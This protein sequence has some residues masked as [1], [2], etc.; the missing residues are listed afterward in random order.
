MT[1]SQ[2]GQAPTGPIEDQ[3]S[4]KKWMNGSI[5]Y[6][7]VSGGNG[8]FSD[9]IVR[10]HLKT[11]LKRSGKLGSFLFC[12]PPILYPDKRGREQET[13]EGHAGGWRAGK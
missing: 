2:P 10:E 8:Q 1:Q 12:L 13:N 5:R 6:T 9:S 3:S 11:V 4:T 7:R